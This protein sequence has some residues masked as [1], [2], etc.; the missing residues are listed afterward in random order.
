MP[1]TLA[2]ASF[3]YVMSEGGENLHFIDRATGIDYAE[4]SP[5]ASVK[6]EGAD[7]PVT[8]ASCKGDLLTLEFGA[9]GASAVV[10]TKIEPR[11]L[12]LE[13][14]AFTGTDVE[15]LTF[16][17]VAL[18]LTGTLRDPF[19]ACALALNLR[20]NVHELPGPMS[21]LRAMCYPQFG[22]AGAAT[23]I[24]ACPIGAMRSV[25]QEV[26]SASPDL[27]HSPIGG[28]WALDA[29]V[30]RG[31]YLFNFENL[32]EA[33]VDGWIGL[34]RSLGI[35]QIDFHGGTSFRFGDC[36][37]N[38]ETYPE[39]FASLKRVIDRL[40]GAGIK[41]G[42]HTYA[43]FIDKKC[44]WVT[45]VPDPRLAKDATFTLKARV[46]ANSGEV[47]VAES[48][49]RMSA[50]TGFFVRNSNTVQIDDEL[51]TY[52]AVAK[53]GR[54]AFLKC[55]RGAN[56]TKPMGHKPGAKVHHL[57]ECFGLFVPDPETT[58]FGE[59]AQ[60]AADAF[61]ECGFDMTYMDALD[62]EDILGGGENAWHY[63]S[64]YVFEFFRRIKRPALFEASTFHHHLWFVRSRIGAWD[65]PSRSHKKFI[66]IHVAANEQ[67]KRMFLPTHLGWWAIKVDQGHQSDPT[68][69]DDIEYLCCKALGTDSGF[70]IMGINPGNVD[71]P[72]YRRL[73]AITQRYEELRHGKRF[74][75]SVKA[76]LR[77]PGAG[78]TLVQKDDGGWTFAPV[79][80]DRHRVEGLDGWSGRWTVQNP[81]HRQ[82]ARLRIEALRSAEP[83][84]SPEAIEIADF[85]DPSSFADRE[86]AEG[87]VAELAAT[88]DERHPDWACGR[89]AARNTRSLAESSAQEAKFSPTEH[90]VRE[91]GKTEPLW[92]KA[93]RAFD[94]PL[95]LSGHEAL[96]VWICGDGRGEV[97]NFQLRCPEHVVAGIGEHYVLVDFTGWR[98]V[99]LIEPEGERADRYA[100]PYSGHVYSIYREGITYGQIRS[101]S[102]WYND[103][104]PGM[105]VSCTISPIHALPLVKAKL[106]NPTIS[107]A[108][109]RI[110]FPVEMESGW[111]LEYNSFEDCILYNGQG[112]PVQNVTP[113]GEAPLLAE[114]D[115]EVRFS[116]ETHDGVIPRAYVTVMSRG[117]ALT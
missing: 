57:K 40:H 59:V 110:V 87:I 32:S 94:P 82:P 36:F 89:Y 99:T 30:N 67:Q 53:D 63:G 78:F 24:I 61:N 13:V 71:R 47:P 16:A 108:G 68:F 23:A 54:H 80:H 15:E 52:E 112:D 91:P 2:N 95:D 26:V 56:G 60:R 4:R 72:I 77:E 14:V 45:P 105:S 98:Y 19:A 65:H 102:L 83:Y 70:S 106:E 8:S 86:A 11:Y 101:L 58:L 96:G 104:R 51:I 85:S 117:N 10:R 42:L 62:G 39:G 114:R 116:C 111:Y 113:Q 46:S 5:C 90:G 38:P 50:V 115:N 75:E 41:A 55:T 69:A 18:R 100:W 88:R 44:P 21:R 17:N 25:M 97:L 3:R 1:I 37:P 92:A 35:N 34:A 9:V 43:F 22:F 27:P 74:D 109:K 73:S 28:P 12:V 64:R 33:T 84:D 20:T 93:G 49:E 29:D 79:H 6:K 31:S 48:M 76:K 7:H 107:S 81:F 103:V 66:D